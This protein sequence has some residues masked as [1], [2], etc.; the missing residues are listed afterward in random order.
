[1]MVKVK[2]E[3]QIKLMKVNVKK[4]NSFRWSLMDEMLQI[5]NAIITAIFEIQ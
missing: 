2:Q 4:T 1:M 5:I 3:S